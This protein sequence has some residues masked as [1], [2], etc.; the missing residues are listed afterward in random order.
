M[1]ILVFNNLERL[2]FEMTGSNAE[3]TK[4]L[5]DSLTNNGQYHIEKDVLNSYEEF[6]LLVLVKKKQHKRLNLFYKK[7]TIY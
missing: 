4:A 6:M 3:E 5:M 2:I 7:K 1:D